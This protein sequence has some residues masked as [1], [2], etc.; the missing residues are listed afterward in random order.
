MKKSI[1]FCQLKKFLNLGK[2]GFRSILTFSVLMLFFHASFCD[3][4]NRNNSSSNSDFYNI[5]LTEESKKSLS[6]EEI[7]RY[8]EL[9]NRLEKKYE[10]LKI[11]NLKPEIEKQFWKEGNFSEWSKFFQ[12]VFEPN[13]I[14]LLAPADVHINEKLHSQIL[15]V[16]TKTEEWEKLHNE[17]KNLSLKICSGSSI[18]IMALSGLVKSNFIGMLEAVSLLWN[19]YQRTDHLMKKLGIYFIYEYEHIKNEAVKKA[20]EDYKIE[21]RLSRIFLKIKDEKIPKN[22]T[23]NEAK[24]EIKEFLDFVKK[25]QKRFQFTL[26]GCF[27]MQMWDVVLS[28]IENYIEEEVLNIFEV[29]FKSDKRNFNDFLRDTYPSAFSDFSG[30]SNSH[31]PGTGSKE[32]MLAALRTIIL[33]KM[34]TQRYPYIKTSLVK[35]EEDEKSE[36]VSI[37]AFWGKIQLKFHSDK[38]VNVGF[39]EGEK[40]VVGEIFKD[41]GNWWESN[42]KNYGVKQ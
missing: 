35:L 40:A 24:K 18:A 15:F 38:V 10:E 16:K 2:L 17:A 11:E 12:E 13:R 3:F 42:K 33:Q 32:R 4:L 27:P 1:H 8:K 21:P 26:P 9:Y 25:S 39:V 19:F 29:F 41:F 20:F 28:Y 36:K 5:V 7:Q 31:Q 6:P 34:G 37:K 30:G 23:I 22:V 14:K